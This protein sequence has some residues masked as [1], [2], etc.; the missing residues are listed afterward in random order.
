MND[1]KQAAAADVAGMA[2]RAMGVEA[3]AAAQPPAQP[4]AK[5]PAKDTV[6]DKAAEAGSPQTEG[7]KAAA[8]P[9]LYDIPM[10]DKS[11]QMTPQQI[12]DTMGRY[13]DLNYKQ[14][15][16]KPIIDTVNELMRASGTTNPAEFASHLKALAAANQA[17]PTMGNTKGDVSGDNKKAAPAQSPDQMAEALSKWEEDN[18]ASLPPGYKE[19]LMGGSQTNAMMQQMQQMQRMLSAVLAQSSGTADAAK[20]AM[21]QAQ[22]Q[23]SQ[24]IQQQIANN[25]DR[26]QAA[27][28]IPDEKANDFMI[29]AA[30]RGYTLEDFVDQNLTINVMRDFA[31]NMA[32]PEMERMRNIAQRR[33]AFTGSMGATPGAPGASTAPAS[34]GTTFDKMADSVMAKRGLA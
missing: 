1:P 28:K 6:Q 10:G 8:D 17:N 25:I 2:A 3:P 34:E 15:Q 16:Y 24:A 31:N 14:A 27:L 29:F 5:P 12:A 22:T 18:A 20:A 23:R 21:G 9:V 19:M 26:V 11:R 32:S 30:E 4:P 13:A 33:Q 7:D